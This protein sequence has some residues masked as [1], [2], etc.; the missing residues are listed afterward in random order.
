[1]AIL[2]ICR[3]DDIDGCRYA[4]IA[5]IFW[6]QIHRKRGPVDSDS[7]QNYGRYFA[8][9]AQS[10]DIQISAISALKMFADNRY[11]D[12]EKK[13]RYADIADADIHIGTS[14]L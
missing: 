3:Y 14:F 13:C 4:D 12:I 10:A 2:P 8:D 5:D 11:A 1:M 6:I 9:M 7:R